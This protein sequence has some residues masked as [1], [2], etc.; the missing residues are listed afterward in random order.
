M[1]DVCLIGSSDVVLRYELLSR[2]TARDALSTYDLWQPYDNAIALR[3]V[4]IGAAVSLANDLDWYIVRFVDEVLVREPSITDE[5]WLSRGLANEVRSDA[6]APAETDQFCKVYGLVDHED[7]PPELVEP[8]FVQ[9]TDDGL[10]PYDLR[11]DVEET[12]V[13]RV[14]EGEFAG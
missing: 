9:R 7:G 13:V 4:S 5:E 12:V 3:T 8:L 10:P 2:E 14:T 6:V 1:T 11:P